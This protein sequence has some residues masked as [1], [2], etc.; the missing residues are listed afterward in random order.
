M[1]VDYFLQID[2][3]AGESQDAKHKGAITVLS[4]S[5]GESS[6]A[7]V[8]TGGGAGAGKV[9]FSDF[10]FMMPVSKA[11]PALFLAC[12]TGQH[13]KTAKLSVQKAGGKAVDDYLTWTFSDVL[14]TSYQASAGGGDDG[15][16]ESVSLHTTKAVVSYKPQKADGSFDTAIAAG[17]DVKTNKKV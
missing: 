14:V 2:G 4:W 6:P 13:F 8:V 7:P 3:I 9:T 15:P 17:F 16:T 12:A 5:W 1:A 11:S 10:N